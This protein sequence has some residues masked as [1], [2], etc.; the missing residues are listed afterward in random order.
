MIKGMLKDGAAPELERA[1][2]GK[3]LATALILVPVAAWVGVLGLIALSVGTWADFEGAFKWADGA[4]LTAGSLYL[5]KTIQTTV[6]QVR[7]PPVS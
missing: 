6:S 4:F 2:S 3:V 5:F 7:K 1:S